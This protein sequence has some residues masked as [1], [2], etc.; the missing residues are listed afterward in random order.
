MLERIALICL[1]LFLTSPALADCLTI[2]QARAKAAEN[3]VLI[4]VLSGA[5]LTKAAAIYNALS[6]ESDN[7]FETVVLVDLPDGGGLLA[8]GPSGQVCGAVRFNSSQWR[9]LRNAL[10]G[11]GA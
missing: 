6:P 9:V 8:V 7:N 5:T 11:V 3:S 1:A 10:F 2:D 4:T